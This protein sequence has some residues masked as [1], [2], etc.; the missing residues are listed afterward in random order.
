MLFVSFSEKLTREAHK[1]GSQEKLIREAPKKE[2]AAL[3][4]A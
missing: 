2:I 1:R 3:I 4:A